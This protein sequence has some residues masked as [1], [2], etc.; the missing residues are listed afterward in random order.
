VGGWHCSRLSLVHR[1]EGKVVPGHAVKA[2]QVN[3]GGTPLI[4]SLHKTEMNSH[5]QPLY[6]RGKSPG[7]H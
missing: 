4:S 6:P 1:G 5:P 3:G 2:Y 7:T